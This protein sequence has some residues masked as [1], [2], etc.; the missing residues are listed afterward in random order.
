MKLA[1]VIVGLLLLA[2]AVVDLVALILPPE[3]RA[4][5]RA[6]ARGF[7]MLVAVAMFSI[8]VGHYIG[9]W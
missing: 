6:E 4:Q 8:A 2:I 1:F 9:Y 5:I 3:R 7:L